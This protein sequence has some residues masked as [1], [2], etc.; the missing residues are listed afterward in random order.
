METS[1]PPE[2]RAAPQ[3]KTGPKREAWDPQVTGT[4]RGRLEL[5]GN[6]EADVAGIGRLNDGA[7]VGFTEARI[8]L[9]EAH[10]HIPVLIVKQ[11][12]DVGLKGQIAAGDAS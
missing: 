6:P 11:V 8:G 12:V 4:V 3:K 9:R 1:G 2:S 5:T 10:G 7:W